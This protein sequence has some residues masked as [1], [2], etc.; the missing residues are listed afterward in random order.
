MVT[1]MLRRVVIIPPAI[2]SWWMMRR[3]F[4]L[5]PA[6]VRINVSYGLSLGSCALILTIISELILLRRVLLL[7]PTVH[8]PEMGFHLPDIP[9]KDTGG[10][11]WVSNPR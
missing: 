9:R 1:G 7:L 6:R 2:R 8:I 4:I 10:E 11:R 3:V 5:L